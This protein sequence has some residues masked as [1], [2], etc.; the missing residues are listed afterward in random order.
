MLYLIQYTHVFV[1]KPGKYFDFPER[2]L[3]VGL[4]FERR[5]LLY[6]HFGLR[7]S[8]KRRAVTKM[9]V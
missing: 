1:F 3:T 9:Q 6:R 4:M 7:H 5:N 8:V 2:P